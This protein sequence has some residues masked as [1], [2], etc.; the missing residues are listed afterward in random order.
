M[1]GWIEEDKRRG[2]GRGGERERGRAEEGG[3]TMEGEGEV[4]GCN[5]EEVVQNRKG[6]HD[7]LMHTFLKHHYNNSFHFKAVRRQCLSKCAY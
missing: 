3:E 2:R 4:R 5:D 6:K 1:E 7:C